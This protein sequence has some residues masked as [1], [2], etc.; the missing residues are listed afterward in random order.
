VRSQPSA[1]PRGSTEHVSARDH[2]RKRRRPADRQTR[3]AG[4]ICSNFWLE[5][6]GQVVLSEWRVALLEAVA[7]TGSISAAAARQGVH[8]RV[9]WRKLQEMEARL[10][11]KLTERTTG[12]PRGGGTRLTAEGLDCVRRFRQFTAGLQDLIAQRFDEAFE[13]S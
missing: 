10:G 4:Q 6:D 7:D 2:P 3:F 11:T 1:V 13:G 5:R 9:A 12:G 8:F